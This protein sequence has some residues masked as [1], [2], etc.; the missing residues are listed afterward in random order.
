[1]SNLSPRYEFDAN[2]VKDALILWLRE[3]FNNNGNHI[4]AVVGCSG[5]KDST[6]VLA[7]LTQA[8][9]PERIY[10]VLMPNGEQADIA[11]SYAVCEYLGLT[12]HVCNIKAGYDGIYNAVATEFE[13]TEQARI[14]LAPVLRMATLKAVSQCVN[15]RFTCNANK[16][17]TYLGWYTLDGDDRGA[18][19]PLA[20]LTAS[21]VVAVGLALGLPRWM[22]EKTPADGLC[23]ASDEEKFGFTY[24]VADRYIETG[25]IDDLEAKFKI[26]IMHIKNE[27]K[28]RPIPVFRPFDRYAAQ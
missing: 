17:E 11:D 26:D 21:Q 6:V 23:G 2:K 4:N 27:F 5:G 15:G 20:G 1:M 3:Y 19:K 24:A 7:A 13:M 14:N 8:I 10:P 18:I 25:E 9:G 28:Q 22:V 12:P 16:T